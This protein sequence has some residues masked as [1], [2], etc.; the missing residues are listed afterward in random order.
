MKFKLLKDKVF[1]EDWT[2]RDICVN[3]FDKIDWY[4]LILFL[5]QDNIYYQ[6]NN[7]NLNLDNS[8]SK[9]SLYFKNMNNN[10]LLLSIYLWKIR[11]NGFFMMWEW[12]I[13][14][15]SPKEIKNYDDLNILYKFLKN[16]SLS[17]DKKLYITPENSGDI[18]LDEI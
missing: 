14:D 1:Y 17:I 5:N 3:F 13:L 12:C 18:I 10:T 8:I 9:I 16:L 7:E 6:L 15:I 11:V 4:K 2:L